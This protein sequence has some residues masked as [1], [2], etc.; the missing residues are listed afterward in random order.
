M[1][2]AQGTLCSLQG[3]VEDTLKHL[4]LKHLSLKF[5]KDVSLPAVAKHWPSL[6]TLSLPKC[7]VID[8]DAD[9]IIPE[10]SARLVNLR[11]GGDIAIRTFEA[12]LGATRCVISLRLDEDLFVT[13][14]VIRS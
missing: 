5:V 12:L 4:P 6:E 1:F 8:D 7:S 9:N 14:F 13:S 11:L 3:L 10:S 2:I